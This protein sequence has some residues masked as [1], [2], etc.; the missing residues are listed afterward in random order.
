MKLKKIITLVIFFSLLA[1]TIY[2]V[3]P[4]TL[5]TPGAVRVVRGESIEELEKKASNLEETF[6]EELKKSEKMGNILEKLGARYVAQGDWT[7]CIKTLKKAIGY[8]SG[9]AKVHHTIAIAYSNRGKETI[10]KDDIS[11]AVQHYKMAIE[12]NEKMLDSYYGL[13]MIYYY[14]KKID[15]AKKQ[16]RSIITKDNKYY[17]ARFAYGK[18]QYEGGK[19][20]T[21]LSVYQNLL[22]DLESRKESSRIDKLKQQCIKNISQITSELKG[23]AR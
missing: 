15:L 2:I 5:F 1:L 6:D 9:G 23:S 13:A 3:G 19:K 12:K 22:S 4:D 17:Q 10:S 18:I 16:L 8:G 21:S 14:Q 11:L 7:Q 20:L